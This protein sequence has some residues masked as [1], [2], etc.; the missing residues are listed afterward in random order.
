MTKVIGSFSHY[1]V[2]Q[3][4]LSTKH[5]GPLFVPATLLVDYAGLWKRL[6]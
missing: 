3:Y 4:A 6:T 1:I 2:L 5:G